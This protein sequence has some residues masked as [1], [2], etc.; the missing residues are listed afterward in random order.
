MSNLRLIAD[1][2]G[3]LNSDITEKEAQAMQR[4]IINLFE[5]WKLTENEAATLLGGINP[6]TFHRCKKGEYGRTSIDL[7][8]RMS[9]LMG[10]HKALRLLFKDAVQGYEWIRRSNQ[11]FSNH[12][13]LNIMLNGDFTD[14]MR[15]RHY[16]DAQR[17]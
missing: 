1:E 15:I 3:N 8:A 11:V 5:R 14:L 12:S 9:N 16:L 2:I 13:A 4:A 6:R 7:N 10:I 17:S